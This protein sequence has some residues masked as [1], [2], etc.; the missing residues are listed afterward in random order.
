MIGRKSVLTRLTTHLDL[1]SSSHRTASVPP[2]L[3]SDVSYCYSINDPGL[4]GPGSGETWHL[5]LLSMTACVYTL[6]VGISAGRAVSET[7]RRFQEN[8][9]SPTCKIARFDSPLEYHSPDTIAVLVP[10][11]EPALTSSKCPAPNS[12]NGVAKL[13]RNLMPYPSR[14]S[15]IQRSSA[16]GNNPVGAVHSAPPFIESR[17][18]YPCPAAT[19]AT[20]PNPS[21]SVV[22]LRRA[23]R[24]GHP[25]QSIARPGVGAQ[26][27]GSK[28]PI[29]GSS[30]H[31]RI[32]PVHVAPCPERTRRTRRGGL[33]RVERERERNHAALK[34]RIHRFEP[35]SHADLWFDEPSSV[36]SAVSLAMRGRAGL[37]VPH[38]GVRNR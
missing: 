13:R 35:V 11:A 6:R 21:R 25:G 34:A 28:R 22:R 24:H 27:D 9:A 14:L 7:P 12:T 15:A 10:H 38:N 3:H 2:L 8:P 36:R 1:R 19:I 32:E 33:T 17:R 18:V 16:P 5:P 4:V 23:A 37:P 20:P 26:V 29:M 31:I 30:I